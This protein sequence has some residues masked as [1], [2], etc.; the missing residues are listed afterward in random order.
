MGLTVEQR[1]VAR[2]LIPD[3]RE[4]AAVVYSSYSGCWTMGQSSSAVRTA[5]YWG[6]EPYEQTQAYPG[7]SQLHARDFS[8]SDANSLLA[9]ARE[10]MKVPVLG[11]EIKGLYPDTQFRAALDLAIR[12]H[13][14]GKYSVGL[15]PT[16]YNE[17]LAKLSGRPGPYELLTGK[18]DDVPEAGVKNAGK[19][20]Y[21]AT[22]ERGLQT[23]KASEQLRLFASRAA[24]TARDQELT[25]DLIA[26][27][28]RLAAEEAEPSKE[29]QAG[30]QEGQAEQQKQAAIRIAATQVN[31]FNSVRALVV[32]QAT[33]YPQ[34]REVFLPILKACKA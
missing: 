13:E 24:A 25:F 29:E 15:Y 4:R 19:S 30:Q 12:D 21:E 27:A 16:V 11:R 18:P 32:S 28:D 33:A 2:Y 9:A 31:K 8:E 6:Q 26:L 23:M 5:Q 17:L 10:W 22:T 20:T 7:W 1:V 14:N 34:L 3:E